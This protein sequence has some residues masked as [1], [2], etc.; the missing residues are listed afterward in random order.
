LQVTFQARGPADGWDETLL[1]LM[2]IDGVKN[3]ELA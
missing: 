2:E 1:G 3:V